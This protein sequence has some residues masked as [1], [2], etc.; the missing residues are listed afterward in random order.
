MGVRRF[1]ALTLAALA[2]AC[3]ASGAGAP[4]AARPT[5]TLYLVHHGKHAGIALA[6]DDLP[7]DFPPR[8]DFPRARFFEIGWG[9]RDYYMHPD[10]GVWMAL[11]AALWPTPAALHVA[12]LQE[13]PPQAFARLEVLALPV[14][15]RAWRA[16]IDYVSASFEREADGRPRALGPG[17]YG[18]SRFYGS[19][20]RFYF[21]RTCNAWVAGALRA[22]GLPVA[23]LAAITADQ[24]FAQVRPLA[25]AAG[26]APAAPR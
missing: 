8:R 14:S 20:E 25:A 17:Q 4:D 19:R 24:L 3:A 6:A 21:P 15:E 2:S 23:P 26:G 11:R 18:A 10:P 7:A 13:A 5:H 16:V 1:L 9:D 22:A 12:A